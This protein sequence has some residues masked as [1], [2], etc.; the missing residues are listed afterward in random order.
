MPFW[1]NM[2]YTNFHGVNQDWI[3]KT[4]K[5][6]VEEWQ[7]YGDNLQQAYDA[8]T[9]TVNE[10]IAALD[11][12]WEN[13]K[14]DMDA[15]FSDLHDYVYN[16]FDNLDVQD[17][18]D[19]KLDEMTAQGLWDD[20]LHQFFDNYTEV[21]D[22]KV[23]DQDAIIADQTQRIDLM[24]TEMDTFLQTHGTVSATLRQET[25]LF[26]GSFNDSNNNLTLEY[27]IL[28]YDYIEVKANFHGNNAIQRFYPSEF[29]TTTGASFRI[30][31]LANGVALT[32]AAVWIGELNMHA[33]NL[34]QEDTQTVLE[35]SFLQWR[36]LGDSDHEGVQVIGETTFYI[37]D[38]VGI[39]YTDISAQKDPELTDI[40]VGADGTVYPT[41]GDAV[42]SYAKGD[43]GLLPEYTNWNEVTEPGVYSTGGYAA[44]HYYDYP[45]IAAPG[46]LEVTRC[47]TDTD[48]MVLQRFYRDGAMAF[49]CATVDSVDDSIPTGGWT[50]YE[51]I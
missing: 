25:S 39:K 24:R 46:V 20:I 13:Y 26:S 10:K 40:R 47:S 35:C 37:T 11:L 14:S 33:L 32:P 6:L 29:I 7:A 43:R 34:Q 42:R 44:M 45:S 19:H 27:N 28:D 48:D 23:A 41:A 18:I 1:E 3:I 12:T 50:I 36:W 2:P 9:A 22:Q 17:E 38:I 16:Y 51:P 30:P 15:A 49:R 5:H 8:F 31:N 21:I 4:T